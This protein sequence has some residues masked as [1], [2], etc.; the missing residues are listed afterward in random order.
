[1]RAPWRFLAALL[2]LPPAVVFWHLERPR[3]T[4]GRS[5]PPPMVAPSPRQAVDGRDTGAGLIARN[6]F[7]RDR[8]P[9][10]QA[11]HTAGG[12]TPS[13]VERPVPLPPRPP[14]QVSGVAWGT[15]PSAVLEG[16]PGHDGGIVVHA[17]D[18]LGGVVVVRIARTDVQVQGFD[19]TWTL[20][21]RQPW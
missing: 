1:M 8:R 6:P 12:A 16:L 15:P 11:Y 4:Q 10:V 14:L 17:G 21:V 13:G 9:A 20:Q 3:V 19:T 18:T 2:A 7:R 5:D